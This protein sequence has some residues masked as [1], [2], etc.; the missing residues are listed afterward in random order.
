MVVKNHGDQA[1]GE[2]QA[3]RN[4]PSQFEPNRVKGDLFA[5]PSALDISAVE[6]VRHDGQQRAKKK[7]KHGRAPFALPERAL[8]AL[9]LRYHL[10]RFHSPSLVRLLFRGFAR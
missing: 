4:S 6:I 2:D 7:L 8:L 10:S 9:L 5:E 3:R 1:H